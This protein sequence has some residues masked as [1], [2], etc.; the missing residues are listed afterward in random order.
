MICKMVDNCALSAD[1]SIGSS[2]NIS[3]NLRYIIHFDAGKSKGFQSYYHISKQLA[4]FL[5]LPF[6]TILSYINIECE[7]MKY[8]YDNNLLLFIEYNHQHIITID[9]KLSTLFGIQLGLVIDLSSLRSYIYQHMLYN[10]IMK[11]ST[12]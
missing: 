8:C 10:S 7:I 1:A 6:D 5:K 9:S 12:I 4:T 3:P 2:I 11:F